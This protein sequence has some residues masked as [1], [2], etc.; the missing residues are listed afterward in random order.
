MVP[1]DY[2]GFRSFVYSKFR[3]LTREVKASI[4]EF[5]LDVRQMETSPH[6]KFRQMAL[7]HII[8]YTNEII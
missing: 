3:L 1:I 4:F 5:I 2:N 6:L 7:T 8:R